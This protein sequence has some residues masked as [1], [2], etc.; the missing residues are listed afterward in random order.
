[1][2]VNAR[3]LINWQTQMSN[4]AH[5]REV[6]DLQAAGLNPVLSAKFGGASTP[7]GAMD[8]SGSG[9]GYSSGSGSGQERDGLLGSIIDGLDPKGS[10]RIGKV[11]IP[12]SVIISLYDYGAANWSS[13]TSMVGNMFNFDIS[14]QDLR[15]SLTSEGTS[16]FNGSRDNIS[17]LDPD[18]PLTLSSGKH[19]MYN[20]G[21]YKA[22]SPEDNAAKTVYGSSNFEK[23]LYKANPR[24]LYIYYH[25][26]GQDWKTKYI[27][28]T[29]DRLS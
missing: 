19:N 13:L 20:E 12:N 6:A 10:I 5:Q 9:G 8:S 25:V 29:V 4:T 28:N 17:G 24:L 15:T 16:G 18:D 22:F 23:A 14:E 1:M 7:S 27:E 26:T 21:L 2:S 3:Q 11:S